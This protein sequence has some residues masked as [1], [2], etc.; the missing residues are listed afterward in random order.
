MPRTSN[1]RPLL[2]GGAVGMACCALALAAAAKGNRTAACSTPIITSAH[3]DQPKA[4]ANP[5]PMFAVMA[6]S[7][8]Y[9]LYVTY[10]GGPA[11]ATYRVLTKF[12]STSSPPNYGEVL[13]T[14]TSH[15]FHTGE[16]YQIGLKVANQCGETASRTLTGVVPEKTAPWLEYVALGDSYSSGEGNPPFSRGDCHL[17]LLSWPYTVGNDYPNGQI[18]LTTNLACSGAHTDALFHPFHGQPSEL[19]QLKVWRADILTITIGGNDVG[20][21]KVLLNCFLLDCV[22]DGRMAKADADIRKL[23]SRLVYVF[24]RLKKSET[25]ARIYV[26]GYPRIFPSSQWQALNCGW[27]EP[28]ERKALNDATVLLDQ[29]ER[30][31]AQ[32]VGV[33][34]IS[35][36]NALNNHELCTIDSW[37]VPIASKANLFGQPRSADGHPTL[38]GQEAIAAIVLE[39]I[40]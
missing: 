23:R 24:G 16:H 28:E 32:A 26:V 33:N 12:L 31:A 30:S 9:A 36:L 21:G 2:A 3:M 6:G 20:F 37:L 39:H 1:I 17:S 18:Q 10:D 35:T 4:G 25:A 7:K 27:L 11:T 29:V 19:D 5:H 15:R 22:H 14:I 38:L 40:L 13:M 8:T 34:Y